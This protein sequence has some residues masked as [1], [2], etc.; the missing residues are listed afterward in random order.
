MIEAVCHVQELVRNTLD[1]TAKEIRFFCI[2]AITPAHPIDSINTIDLGGVNLF[3]KNNTNHPT[4]SKNDI[5]RYN[6]LTN[7]QFFNKT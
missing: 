3:L 7:C 2:T 4:S 1:F 6:T 5:S